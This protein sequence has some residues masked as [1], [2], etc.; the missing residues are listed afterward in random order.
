MAHT[1]VW[2]SVPLAVLLSWAWIAHVMEIDNAVEAAGAERV[3]KMFK[4]SLPMWANGLRLID[5]EG[6]T[7][8][9]LHR[10]AGASCNVGG[11]ER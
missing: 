11:L 5:E 3:G 9:D 1:L 8:A 4:I 10:R 7:A 2:V 6:I